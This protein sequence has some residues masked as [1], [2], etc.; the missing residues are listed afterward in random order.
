MTTKLRKMKDAPGY[1]TPDE[2]F[3]VEHYYAG[4]VPCWKV[5]DL[6]GV[7][8]FGGIPTGK[9]TSINVIVNSL[10]EAEAAIE[11][12]LTRESYRA[13]KAKKGDVVLTEG[14]AA[15]ASMSLALERGLSLPVRRDDGFPAPNPLNEGESA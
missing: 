15:I 10:P 3:V 13:R 4:L 12:A 8:M 7:L 1:I 6:T 5:T 14:Q 11:Q 9:P 2:R